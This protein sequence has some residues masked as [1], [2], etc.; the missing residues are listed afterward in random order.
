M[1][2][3]AVRPQCGTCRRSIASAASGNHPCP[4]PDRPCEYDDVL[5]TEIGGL[6]VPIPLDG[7][8]DI[9]FGSLKLTRP[10]RRRAE[11]DAGN[12]MSDAPKQQQQQQHQSEDV[13]VLQRQL[14]DALARS[15]RLQEEIRRMAESRSMESHDVSRLPTPD[16]MMEEGGRALGRRWGTNTVPIEA[17]LSPVAGSGP[18][19]RQRLR[20]PEMRPPIDTHRAVQG[21]DALHRALSPIDGPGPTDDLPIVL[22]KTT[23]NDSTAQ[24]LWPDQDRELPDGS[25]ITHLCELFFKYHPLRLLVNKQV[26]DRAREWTAEKP[27]R[28]ASALIHAIC[29]AAC[30]YSPYNSD[31]LGEKPPEGDRRIPFLRHPSERPR[32]EEKGRSFK[33]YHLGQAVAKVEENVFKNSVNPTQWI[34][35][36]IIA[37][38]ELWS[39]I[40]FSEAFFMSSAITRSLCVTGLDKVSGRLAENPADG[41]I[42]APAEDVVTL[43]ER[44]Q[45]LWWAYITDQCTSGPLRC[46]E[47]SLDDKAVS[48]HIPDAAAAEAG[49]K[50]PLT[51]NLGSRDLFSTGHVDD[52][53]LLIKAC[54]LNK[55]VLTFNS[56]QKVYLRQPSAMP[57]ISKWQ[58]RIDELE[59]TFAPFDAT[60]EQVTPER[61]YAHANLQMAILHLFE[62][63]MSREPTVDADG[64]DRASADDERVRKACSNVVRVVRD[65]IRCEYDLRRLHAQVYLAWAT[66]GRILQCEINRAQRVSLG[67]TTTMSTTLSTMNGEAAGT[68]A[69]RIALLALEEEAKSG[70]QSILEA[71]AIGGKTCYKASHAA[72]LLTQF[73]NGGL[74]ELAMADL[75]YIDGVIPTEGTMQET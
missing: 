52:F 51:Q 69:Q 35:A 26:F 12:L 46:Y 24:Q 28:P 64:E 13:I 31:R 3:D 57:S 70:L 55:H 34:N 65:L 62:H 45:T 60:R 1:K 9:P 40:R 63:R 38:Y 4:V 25:V 48:T 10:K 50:E 58:S 54:V 6:S 43:H 74:P 32:I 19:R 15:A 27:W 71:L 59:S 61:I 44:R 36:A 42:L 11:T 73:A 5:S 66:T 22:Q 75:L 17:M 47:G 20:Y 39:D 33:Q 7:D 41:G 8:S 72:G 49:K 37:C 53:V 56:R 68:E 67:A 16:L 2:C 29:A 30:I 23:L 14:K 18:P 21:S